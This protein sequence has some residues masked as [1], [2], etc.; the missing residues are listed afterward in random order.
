MP[1]FELREVINFPSLSA[2]RHYYEL[3]HDYFILVSGDG[4]FDVLLEFW[5]EK[6]VFDKL[7]I[8]YRNM[9]SKLL[10]NITSESER[11]DLSFARK[12]LSK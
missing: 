7:I 5:K 3:N 11:Y 8:P 10:K 4:D 2:T 1:I 6:G 12:K 9:T